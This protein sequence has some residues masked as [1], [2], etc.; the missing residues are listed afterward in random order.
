M[1]KE[2]AD[3]LANEYMTRVLATERRLG[4]GRAPNAE[5]LDK[6]TREVADVFRRLANA[7]SPSSSATTD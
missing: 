4:Q 2:D 7:A 6:A 5:R 1:T 3:K